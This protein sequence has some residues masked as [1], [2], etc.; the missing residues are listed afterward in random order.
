M[1]HF[2]VLSV[3]ARD[4]VGCVLEP[5]GQHLVI[6]AGGAGGWGLGYYKAGDLLRRIEPRERGEE[7]DVATIVEGLVSE[8]LVLHAREATVGAVRR[9]NTHP[10]RFQDWLFAHNGTLEG[11]DSYRGKM[12]E[13]MPPFIN[14]GLKGDTDSEHLFHLFLSFLYDAG[15]LSRPDPGT[16]VIREALS[17]AMA[18]VDAFAVESGATRSQSSVV[19]SDGY[20]L[21]VLSRGVPV[22][23]QLV[24]GIR[25]CAL[26]R[27]SRTSRGTPPSIDHDELRAVLV[28]SGTGSEECEGFQL[29]DEAT[30]LSVTKEHRIEFTPFG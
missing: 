21:V 29:L 3:N 6:P 16:A 17:Q 15:H 23:Y 26:C 18:M 20:S 8:L 7:L 22:C 14:R 4:N 28:R 25:D 19:V 5:L 30:F 1:S 13:A 24:E 9:E 11:F 10:F 12:I 2:L 27:I